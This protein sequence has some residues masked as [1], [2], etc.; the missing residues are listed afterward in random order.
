MNQDETG[1]DCGGEKCDPC[2]Y[3]TI[4]ESCQNDDCHDDCPEGSAPV[5][6][7]EECKAA[8]AGKTLWS[9]L[10]CGERGNYETAKLYTDS[11]GTE[12][13][14]AEDNQGPPKML[15]GAFIERKIE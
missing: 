8:V 3:I 12:N 14:W 10:R 4:G 2:Q 9:Y 6:T 11:C 1:K 5:R 15:R 7:L 13:V